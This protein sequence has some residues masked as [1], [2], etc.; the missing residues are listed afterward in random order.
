LL[1]ACLPAGEE[2]DLR[3]ASWHLTL[4]TT[5]KRQWF[6][7]L[8]VAAAVW[9]SLGLLLPWIL[10]GVASRVTSTDIFGIS[11]NR[12]SLFQV[13]IFIGILFSFGVWSI[14]IVNSTVRA[15]LAALM[16]VVGLA[17]ILALSL[18]FSHEMGGLETGLLAMVSSLPVARQFDWGVI[19]F[20]VAGL[21]LGLM[22]LRQGMQLFRRSEHTR[23]EIVGSALVLALTALALGLWFGDLLQSAQQLQ[24][25][26]REQAHL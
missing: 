12:N 20:Y 18:Q 22:A 5:A 4:P 21:S 25:I 1:T 2:K 17:A 7:R 13:L 24:A 14:N 16:T 15:V 10:A 3:I 23:R 6:V 19:G 11:Q 8:G 26:I 9:V